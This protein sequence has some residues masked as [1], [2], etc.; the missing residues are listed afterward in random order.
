VC[1]CVCDL[2]ARVV[3]CGVFVFVCCLCVFDMCVNI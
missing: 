1:V 3:M 2:F